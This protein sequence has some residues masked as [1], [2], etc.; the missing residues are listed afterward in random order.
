MNYKIRKLSASEAENLQ[1][2]FCEI[3][4]DSVENGASIGFLPPLSVEDAEKYWRGV[5]ENLDSGNLILL[6]AIE[7]AEILGTVQLALAE[8]NNAEHRAEV[9]K[10]LVHSKYRNRG[11]AKSLMD[12]LEKIAVENR[13]T[14]LILDTKKGDAAEKIYEKWNWIRTGEI[15]HY[16]RCADGKLHSTIL[17]YKTL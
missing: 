3:L 2:Q 7:G 17:F 10:L 5:F 8:K 6:A 14:L 9:Q 16:A 1:S 12:K 15:P 4:K 11:V 13:R